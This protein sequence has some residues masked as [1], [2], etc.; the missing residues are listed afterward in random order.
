ME[1]PQSQN[2]TS[3]ESK[4]ESLGFNGNKVCFIFIFMTLI[5]FCTT[6]LEFKCRCREAQVKKNKTKGV[7]EGGAV[8]AKSVIKF[9]IPLPFHF[10]V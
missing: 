9:V 3:T 4:R 5:M 10:Y 2:K 7:I 8:G 1:I 6:E